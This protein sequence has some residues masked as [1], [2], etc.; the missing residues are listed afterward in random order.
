METYFGPFTILIKSNILTEYIYPTKIFI[1]LDINLRH[2]LVTGS[3][4]WPRN[5]RASNS[6]PAF[7]QS[8]ILKVISSLGSCE[9]TILESRLLDT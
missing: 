4:E 5:K 3:L 2:L 8:E 9:T 1:D 7:V 6:K